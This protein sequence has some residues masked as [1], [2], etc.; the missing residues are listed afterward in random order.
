GTSRSPKE[1]QRAMAKMVEAEKAVRGSRNKTFLELTAFE[2]FDTLM[3]PE[4]ATR[5]FYF[6]VKRTRQLGNLGVGLLGPGVGCAAGVRSMTESEFALHR[7]EVGL[8]IRGV[9]P[10][11]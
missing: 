4:E 1:Q 7:D 9:R 8:I 5:I 6:G 11:F 3:G 2:V 10:A